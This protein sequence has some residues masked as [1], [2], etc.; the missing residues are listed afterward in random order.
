[1]ID[2]F[3]EWAF[4][5]SNIIGRKIEVVYTC[6]LIYCNL[7]GIYD[8]LDRKELQMSICQDYNCMIDKG[9]YKLRA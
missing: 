1:M 8:L 4:L 3:I 6:Y 5:D 2:K 9:V 7:F